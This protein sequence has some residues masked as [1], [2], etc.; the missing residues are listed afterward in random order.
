MATPELWQKIKEIVGAALEREPSARGAYLDQACANDGELRA[1]V[2]SLLAAHADADGLSEHPWA[3]TGEAAGESTTIGPYRLLRELGDKGVAIIMI[4]SDMEE[5]LRVSDRVAVMHE[6]SLAGI[7]ERSAC[8]EEAVMNLAVG[9]I[10][11]PV[12]A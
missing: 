7:L 2:E 1:E 11:G 3:S 6:G 10:A 12:A 9:K 8:T 5:V 4:S